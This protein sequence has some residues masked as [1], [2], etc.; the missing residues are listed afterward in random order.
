MFS[1]S[2]LLACALA[3]LALELWL[4]RQEGA[5]P[6]LWGWKDP[7]VSAGQRKA[8]ESN[9]LGYRGR[10]IEYAHGDDVVVLVGDSQVQA[11]ACVFEAMPERRLAAVLSARRGRPVK[12]FSVG[13]MGYGTDQ[14]CLALE[15]YL[16]RY[17]ADVVVVWPTPGND[18][19]EILLPIAPVPKP[20]FWLEGDALRG[21]TARIGEPVPQGSRA[22]QWLRDRARGP[23]NTYWSKHI[24]PP[25]N[26]PLPRRDGPVRTDWG[27][28]S[29]VADNF[30][31]EHVHVLFQI[32]P[33]SPR[34]RYAARLMHRL[35]HRMQDATRA[36]GGALCVLLDERA[37]FPLPDG[38]YEVDTK[39]PWLRLSTG[40]YAENMATVTEGLKVARV[41]VTVSPWVAGPKDPHLNAHAV[42]E[43]MRGLAQTV[44]TMLPAR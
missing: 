15:D 4:R 39:G 24:L 14:E 28:I 9:Q 42:D 23:L 40:A 41:K 19:R 6:M 7:Y 11:D 18:A 37:D 33:P 36:Q 34:A 12:V 17:R 16:T 44:A 43:V 27:V 38:L 22:F 20:T 3:L 2:L 30:A 21:P 35:L 1:V 5:A 10:Q 31:E 32:D 29:L 26:P 13:A 25:V 8:G